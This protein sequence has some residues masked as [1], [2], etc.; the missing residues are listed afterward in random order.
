MIHSSIVWP[1][2]GELQILRH[3]VDIVRRNPDR[4]SAAGAAL[5]VEF[6]TQAIRNR[7]ATYLRDYRKLSNRKRRTRSYQ[8]RHCRFEQISR[9]P[10]FQI[11]PIEAVHPPPRRLRDKNGILSR[12]ELPLRERFSLAFRMTFGDKT[13]LHVLQVDRRCDIVDRRLLVAWLRW[14]PDRGTLKRITAFQDLQTVATDDGISPV[15][16]V[17]DLDEPP[18]TKVLLVRTDGRVKRNEL[19]WVSMAQKALDAFLTDPECG[20]V[21]T[22]VMRLKSALELMVKLETE[23]PLNNDPIH[24]KRLTKLKKQCSLALR[25]CFQSSEGLP[26]ALRTVWSPTVASEIVE[27]RSSIEVLRTRMA[28]YRANGFNH[29]ILRVS[30]A[31]QQ[32]KDE[33]IMHEQYLWK[34]VKRLPCLSL[35]IHEPLNTF[36]SLDAERAT[37]TPEVLVDP[38]STN[39]KGPATSWATKS[40][41]NNDSDG[42]EVD[43][44]FALNWSDST[45]VTHVELSE[46]FGDNREVV[47]KR[48]DRWRHQNGAGWHEIPNRAKNEPR[49]VYAWGAIKDMF[50]GRPIS[51]GKRPPKKK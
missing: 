6:S 5:D 19:A 18:A 48:L 17:G 8:R 22:I 40:P 21:P 3:I 33:W 36:R 35:G 25:A 42:P 15:M 11:S 30:N 24:R 43:P 38:R 31:P 12:P 26:D 1:A 10:G 44:S 14:D 2:E 45:L 9:S 28:C 51:S 13:A 37:P 23:P 29:P 34:M 39:V 41:D 20:V 47:R 32:V 50:S 4:F 16:S 49:Y 46:R 7:K 27:M